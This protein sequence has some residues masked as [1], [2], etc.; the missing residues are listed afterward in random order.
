M[1]TIQRKGKCGSLSA[2]SKCRRKKVLAI[3]RQI[4]VSGIILWYLYTSSF[5]PNNFGHS[6]TEPSSIGVERHMHFVLSG[7]SVNCG[8]W[9]LGSGCCVS[10]LSSLSWL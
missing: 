10:K 2:P 4:Q 7:D 8:C 5:I 6:H 3:R 9:K 1:C